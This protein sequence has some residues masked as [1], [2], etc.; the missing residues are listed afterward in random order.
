MDK[1]ASPS[2]YATIDTSILTT[3]LPPPSPS[4]PTVAFITGTISASKIQRREYRSKT[5]KKKIKKISLRVLT[6]PGAVAL[7]NFLNHSLMWAA[8]VCLLTIWTLYADDLRFL[9]LSKNID[10]TM[11]FINWIIFGIFVFE[12]IADSIVHLGY[13]GSLTSMMDL[14]AAVSLVP[15]DGLT[16]STSVARIART[17]RALRILRATRAA[18]MALKTEA[19]LKRAR[20][21]QKIKKKVAFDLA[22]QKKNGNGVTGT[23][24]IQSKSLL[25]ATLLERGNVK[26]LLGVLILLMGMSLIDY[27]ENDRAAQ[28]GLRMINV[29]LDGKHEK[30]LFLFF[31]FVECCC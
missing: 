25:E 23:T 3:T 7:D 6:S 4:T 8:S 17:F 2:K 16:Q 5:T 29:Q 31:F 13:F 11:S 24:P 26:M 21:A 22:N 14:L 20:E 19:A 18:A 27:A 28:A 10:S 12:W 9:Y 30:F 15:L 1:E